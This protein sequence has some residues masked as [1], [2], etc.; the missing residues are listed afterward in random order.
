MITRQTVIVLGAGASQPFGFPSG[1]ELKN[2]I[3]RDLAKTN[4]ASPTY[5]LMLSAAFRPAAIEDFR[6]ALQNSGKM[7]VDS[8]LEHRA[9]L[10]R[11]GKAAIAAALAP[12]ESTDALYLAPGSW[13]DYF[14]DKLN[15]RFEEFDH[16]SVKVLTF[17]YDRSLE[18]YLFTSL[19]NCYGKS[20]GE[21][22]Q[23][24]RSIEIVHL[25]GQ[26][27]EYPPIGRPEASIRYGPTMDAESLIIAS[28]GIKI[29]HEGEGNTEAFD[30][31]H[32]ILRSAEQV[33]FL[34]FGYHPANVER[35]FGYDHHGGPPITGSTMGLTRKECANISVSIERLGIG[36]VHIPPHP[37]WD[38][39]TFLRE[40]CLFD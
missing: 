22:A 3:V 23:K 21:C 26:L 8:F 40:Y 14:Y 4:P 15:A 30:R 24:L 13:Y 12:Y 1:I 37:E 9:D 2:N 7:S 38:A 39:L 35:L 18:H 29:I 27:G 5:S 10:L 16:N 11:V 36:R 28:D 34:G 20:V 25:Y 6:S 17:N 32:E 19:R 31:A 33:C